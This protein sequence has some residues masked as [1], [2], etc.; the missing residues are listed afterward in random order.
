VG[1]NF[2]VNASKYQSGGKR[3][4]CSSKFL[5]FFKLVDG[6]LCLYLQKK[7]KDHFGIEGDEGST[8]VEDSVSPLK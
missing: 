7:S 3:M 2:V 6:F 4:L 5:D 8:M 1:E